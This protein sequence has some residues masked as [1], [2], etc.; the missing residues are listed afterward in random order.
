MIAQGELISDGNPAVNDSQAPVDEAFRIEQHGID[1]VGDSERWASPLSLC[2]M[3]A[4]AITNFELLV[5]GAVLMSFGFDYIQAVL[6]IILGNVTWVLVGLASLQGPDAGTTT[7]VVNRAPFGPNGNRL[8][9]LF[10][11]MTQVGF[12]TE[13]IALIVLAGIA[14]AT[15]AGVHAGAPLKVVLIVLAGAIQLV[16]PLLGHATIVKTLRVLVAPFVLLFVVLAVLTIGKARFSG[17]IHGASWQMFMT[18]LAFVI[19]VTG[20][21]WTENGNDYSRYLPRMTSRPSVVGWVV[22]G[23]AL[24]SILLMLLGAAVAT[25]VPDVGGNPVTNFPHAFSGWFLI[26]F[27][28]VSIVQLFS[29]NSLDLYSSGLTL[30][31]IGLPLARWQAVLVDTVIACGLTAWAIFVTSFN[32]L[33]TDF[34]DCVIVWIGPWTAIFLVDWWLRLYRYDAIELQRTDEGLY[35]RIGGIHWPAIIAQ[36]LGSVA[37]VL[38]LDTSFYVSPISSATG[39]ADFSV[40]MGLGV[41]AIV[42]YLLAARYVRTEVTIQDELRRTMARKLG[43]DEDEL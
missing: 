9:A 39:G 38:A 10:N 26:P 19:I 36:V 25:Y 32:T 42:Y 20:L 3:W 40:F 35:W 30:Q 14:L 4:G 31:A 37:A 41:G 7:F 23:T 1:R 34:V 6:A 43:V 16:L 22:A 33:I 17:Y 15:K 24:P 18:G 5:Y 28:L 27:L 2:G 12:E 13:G 21:G 29:I 8:I 11:W